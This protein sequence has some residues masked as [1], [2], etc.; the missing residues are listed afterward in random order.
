MRSAAE[1][2][3]DLGL[4]LPDL[5]LLEQAL[6]HSSYDNEHP[7]AATSTNERLEF[8][9]DA[10]VSAVIS[11][12]LWKRF[13]VDDEGMLTARRAHIVS[14]AGLARLGRRLGLGAYLRLGQGAERTGERDRDSVIAAGLEAVAAA[15][16]LELGLDAV[17]SWLLPLAEP[18]LAEASSK[19]LKSAKSALQERSFATASG[20]PRYRVV[21]AEGPDHAKQ[22]LVEVAI[23]GVVLGR[24]RGWNRREAETAAASEALDRLATGFADGP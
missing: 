12:A 9:G 2:A 15:V 19:D 10:V 20:A 6:T 3:D 21:T 11:E 24:G 14:T 1:L 8:L 13:P 5:A 22:Y 23:A 18:E 4:V 17:R 16:Y 7:S